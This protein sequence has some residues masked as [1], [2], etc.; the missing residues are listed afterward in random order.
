VKLSR[1]YY[2]QFASIDTVALDAEPIGQQ[3]LNIEILM[4]LLTHLNAN[5]NAALPQ[6]DGS[7]DG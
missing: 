4:L 1:G 6:C 7:I 3:E 5:P 2:D